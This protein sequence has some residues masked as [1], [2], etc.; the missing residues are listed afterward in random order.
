MD[1]D[2]IATSSSAA[3][4]AE[5]RVPGA[6]RW[7]VLLFAWLTFLI[8]FVDRL[9]W[10]SAAIPVAQD[11]GLQVA[12]LGTFVTAF[13][14]GYVIFNAVGGL[15]SDRVGA[16]LTLSISV[17]LLG[18]CTFGFSFTNSV[19]A[20]LALQTAMGLAAGAD[21]GA[22]I[23]LIVSWFDRGLRGRAMG[24]YMTAS[25]LGVTVTNAVAPTLLRE[26]GWQNVYK[27]LGGVTLAIAILAFLLLRDGPQQ[28]EKR[29]DTAADIG[30]LLRNRNLIFLAFAGFGAMW[31]TWGFAFWANALMI[32]G[33]GVSPVDAGL[34][35]AVVGVAAIIGKPLIGV[36]SDWLGNR[37]KEIIIAILVL[38]MVMLLVF[39]SLGTKAGFLA[40]APLLGV[41]AF[42]YSP[43]L[44]ALV[45]SVSGV[46]LAGSA[47]GFTA[48][49][50]QLGSVIVPVVVGLV[51]QTTGS[52]YSAFITLALGPLLGIACLLFVR[53][54]GVQKV[55]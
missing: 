24:F 26:I 39:G 4:R 50:W 23:K 10:A 45:A 12:A 28:V 49:F 18:L 52:F 53:E 9:V 21:Y 25:S 15:L 48:A 7:I 55:G 3:V 8:S 14:I 47:T 13:Y 51:F 34:V 38:F 5:P 31:G 30:L 6:T 19:A 41:G 36:V 33:H 35:V 43:I 29:R 42:V 37:N 20:G 27:L 1:M 32:K 44:A 17:G 11:L 2:S 54:P 40:A 22:G 46:A 16:R